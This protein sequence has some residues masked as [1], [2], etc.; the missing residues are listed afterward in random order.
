MAVD[1]TGTR[2]GLAPEERAPKQQTFNIRCKNAG[3]DS[4]QAIELRVQGQRPDQRLYQCVKCKST[5]G[6]QVGGVL[7]I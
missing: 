1:H 2:P 3:C 4:I 6:L 7:D 5:H